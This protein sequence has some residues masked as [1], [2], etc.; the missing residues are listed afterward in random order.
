MYPTT[1][2]PLSHP[3][4]L[5]KKERE[6]RYILPFSS[7][8]KPSHP[9]FLPLKAIHL[10]PF[11]SSVFSKQRSR[12]SP[13]GLRARDFKRFPGLTPSCVQRR[14]NPAASSFLKMKIIYSDS[15]TTLMYRSVPRLSSSLSMPFLNYLSI[16]L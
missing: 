15:V 13:W 14:W 11:Q 1:D 10:R 9:L 16:Y 4:T 6:K 5:K 7:V 8:L 12:P 2:Q 3:H